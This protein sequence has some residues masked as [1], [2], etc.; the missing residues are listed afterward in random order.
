MATKP[1]KTSSVKAKSA[2][3]EKTTAP[4]V[5]RARKSDVV[6]VQAV[7]SGVGPTPAFDQIAVRAYERFAERGYQHGFDVED[8]LAAERELA[9]QH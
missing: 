9:R 3:T 8:W 7:Q 6:D 2:K 1:T 4:K 5:S